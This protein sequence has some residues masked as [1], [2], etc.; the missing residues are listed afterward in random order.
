MDEEEVVEEV[1]EGWD[2]VCRRNQR[3]PRHVSMP[4]MRLP[5]TVWIQ[6]TSVRHCAF[7]A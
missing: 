2:E 4:E 5:L 6:E 1:E 7:W 3:C